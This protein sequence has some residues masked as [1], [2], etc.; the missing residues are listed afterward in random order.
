L[1]SNT[2]CAKDITLNYAS[3]TSLGDVSRAGRQDGITIVCLAITGD[4]TDEAL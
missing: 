2:I 1:V 4:K 3:L